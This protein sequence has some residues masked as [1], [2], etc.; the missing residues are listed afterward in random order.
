[1]ASDHLTGSLLRT[2]AASKPK[3][4]LLEL[5]TGTGLATAWLLS[6]MARESRLITVDQDARVASVAKKHLGD[7]P[8]VT[9]LME[10]AGPWLEGASDYRFDLIFADA[11]PGKYKSLLRPI[12][13]SLL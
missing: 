12:A 9:F 2:L 11:W 4:K 10:D 13:A 7:D 1:M 8:R 6:G 5:G 3:G